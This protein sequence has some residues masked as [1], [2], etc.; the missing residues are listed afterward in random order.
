[1]KSKIL[2]A[3]AFL[4]GSLITQAQTSVSTSSSSNKSSVSVSISDNN[5]QSRS[6]TS[7]SVSS[8][9]DSYHLTARFDKH[10]TEKVKSFLMDELG[11]KNHS[12][13]GS[14]H[15]W[16]K[17]ENNELLYLIRLSNGRLK[18]FLDKELASESTIRLFEGMGEEVSE[19]ISGSKKRDRRRR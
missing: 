2:I 17:E 11:T 14:S 19:L 18:I 13:K 15:E 16:E 9:N 10:K 12:A 1:M 3:V 5:G 7:I 8:D 6:S 4:A